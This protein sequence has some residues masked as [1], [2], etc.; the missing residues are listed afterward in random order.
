MVK[1]NRASDGRVERLN[2]LLDWQANE[3][4]TLLRQKIAEAAAFRAYC[5][6]EWSRQVRAV[7]AIARV[8][9]QTHYPEADLLE[10]S[11][12]LPKIRCLHDRQAKGRTGRG[13]DHRGSYTGRTVFGNDD[14][15]YTCGRGRADKRSKIA[16][17]LNRIKHEHP[18]HVSR[19]A[20]HH[21]QVA[22]RQHPSRFDL[23]D[24]ALMIAGSLVEDR[25]IYELNLHV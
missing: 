12:G 10:C 3:H 8:A 19:R 9:I 4:V 1:Q 23:G 20:E 2:G 14:R 6:D 21:H 15:P 7:V 24:N 16:R 11:Y 18:I 17:I 22:E 13:L 25:A 5:D